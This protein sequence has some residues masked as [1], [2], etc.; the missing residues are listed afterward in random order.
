MGKTFQALQRLEI[1]NRQFHAVSEV[2]AAFPNVLVFEINESKS[3]TAYSTLTAQILAL[4]LISYFGPVT[5]PFCASVSLT[6]STVNRGVPPSG[7]G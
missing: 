6:W 1:R 4:P 2:S 7:A 5:P 3:S